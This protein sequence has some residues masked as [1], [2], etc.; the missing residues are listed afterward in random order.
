MKYSTLV[1]TTMK[2]D[3]YASG[4]FTANNLLHDARTTSLTPGVVA[5]A[6]VPLPPIIVQPTNGF[7]PTPVTPTVPAGAA[8]VGFSSMVSSPKNTGVMGF[9][10]PNGDWFI[11]LLKRLNEQMDSKSASS[12]SFDLA[13][14]NNRLGTF[15]FDVERGLYCY[16][17]RTNTMMANMSV[18]DISIS[19]IYTDNSVNIKSTSTTIWDAWVISTSSRRYYVRQMLASIGAGVAKGIGEGANTALDRQHQ[20]EMQANAHDNQQL[21]QSNAHKQELRTGRQQQRYTARNMHSNQAFQFGMQ[22]SS[23]DFQQNMQGNLFEQ[24]Q[25]LQQKDYENRSAMSG[26][27]S[28]AGQSNAGN[29]TYA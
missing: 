22:A 6:P 18:K 13:Y 17:T 28:P 4:P 23:H 7:Q 19:S 12:I 15:Y 8:A 5:W 2:P 20:L 26:Y 3:G 16:P 27:S 9:G 25:Q 11:E 10:C 24:Q 21:L 14:G 29:H 1:T